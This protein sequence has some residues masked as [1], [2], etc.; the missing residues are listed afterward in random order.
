MS[1][2][3]ERPKA[4]GAVGVDDVVAALLADRTQVQVVLVV[5]VELADQLTQA[6]AQPLFELAVGQACG[7]LITQERSFSVTAVG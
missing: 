1:G 7:L 6:N 3:D 2:S 5:L 4:E